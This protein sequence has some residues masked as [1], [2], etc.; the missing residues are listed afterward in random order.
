M[1]IAT[2]YCRLISVYVE[3]TMDCV[4]VNEGVSEGVSEGANEGEC[5][6]GVYSVGSEVSGVNNNL[7]T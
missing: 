7:S 3:R 1:L 6:I 4:G 5:E 2:I